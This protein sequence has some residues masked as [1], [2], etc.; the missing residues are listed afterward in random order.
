MGRVP[1]CAERAMTFK[2][3]INRILGPEF[4]GLKLVGTTALIRPAKPPR[5]THA[6]SGLSADNEQQ[7]PQLIIDLLQLST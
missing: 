2:T 5:R 7:R 4:H 3:S 6:S 1:L